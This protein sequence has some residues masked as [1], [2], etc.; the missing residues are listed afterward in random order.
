MVRVVGIQS[1]LSVF[2]GRCDGLRNPLSNSAVSLSALPYTQGTKVILNV[3]D[4]SP[5]NEYLYSVGEFPV[6]EESGADPFKSSPRPR[7]GPPSFWSGGIR[8]RVQFRQWGRS[9][10]FV[11]ERGPWGEV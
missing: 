3:Y 10:R 6:F 7:F 4:L 11:S 5:A 9:V 2:K 1:K 8:T